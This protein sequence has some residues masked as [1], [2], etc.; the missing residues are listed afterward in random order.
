M[1]SLETERLDL[2]PLTWDDFDFFAALYADPDVAR[3]L[4]AS[5]TKTVA[6]SR[7]LLEQIMRAYSEDSAGQ[8][9]V[10]L[11]HSGTLIG[12]CGVTV[13]EVETV[14]VE[15]RPPRW[16]W[17]RGSAPSDLAVVRELELGY[18]FAKQYW[19]NGYAT[20]SAIAVRDHVFHNGHHERLLAGILPGN[21]AS[22]KVAR[23]LGM[24]H[25]GPIN[26]FG[27]PAEGYEIKKADWARY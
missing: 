3:F 15:G 4:S 1:Y 19:G 2:R 13:L 17:F 14:A 20:E 21:N 27:L 6:E 7:E 11:K 25:I 12:R 5:G 22:K 8:L 18:T 9:A 24:N 10:F 26:A 16:F 23:R